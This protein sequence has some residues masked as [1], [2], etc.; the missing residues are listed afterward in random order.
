MRKR[1][2]ARRTRTRAALATTAAAVMAAA[3]T[4]AL[5]ASQPPSALAAVT[6]AAARTA[7]QSYRFT[8]TSSASGPGGAPSKN[9]FSGIFN[10]ALGIGEEIWTN[11]F[12]PALP[13]GHEYQ[14]EVYLFIGGYI[15]SRINPPK[16]SPLHGKSWIKMR[17]PS[18]GPPS[19][20][21]AEQIAT[22]WSG[23][24]QGALLNPDDVLA[25]LKSVS[26]VSEIG[27]A[28]GPGWTGT[29]YEFSSTSKVQGPLSMT[30]T[31]SGTVEIDQQGRM[32]SIS[33]TLRTTPADSS[34]MPTPDRWSSTI[35]LRDFGVAVSVTAPP[36]SE[37]YTPPSPP[38]VSA[39]PLPA[40]R[41]SS[42]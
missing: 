8:V 32:R 12:N 29:R 18:V 33:D 23:S 41:P 4:V 2:A 30:N 6:A 31:F 27:P 38:P 42:G 35:R 15:Y 13:V 24:P 7:A 5:T 11:V 3:T 36:P 19:G 14:T 17:L 28:S 37:T 40:G 25:V 9:T 21:A 20:N 1:Q 39:P 16:T 26:H 34:V 22:L 10:P